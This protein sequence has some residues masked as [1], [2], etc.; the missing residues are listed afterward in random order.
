[1]D[2]KTEIQERDE[3]IQFLREQ[4]IKAT[5]QDVEVPY[6]WE[7][8]TGPSI[9]PKFLLAQDDSKTFSQ[10][11]KDLD[12]PAP[13]PEPKKGEVLPPVNPDYEKISLTHFSGRG[14]TKDAMISLIGGLKRLTRITTLDLSRNNLNDTF[15][16]EL[17]EI[18]KITKITRVNLSNNEL[19][20]AFLLK[21]TDI[22]KSGGTHL[23]YLE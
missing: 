14:V 7:K 18:F 17:E 3:L 13:A 16:P 20:K 1:M 23:E 5:G 21:F 8:Y 12:L 15:I 4:L 22:I 2:L 11:V 19:G 6:K 9:A 10:A